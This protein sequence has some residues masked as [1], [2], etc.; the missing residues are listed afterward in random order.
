MAKMRRLGMSTEKDGAYSKLIVVC[1]AIL[2]GFTFGLPVFGGVLTAQWKDEY[3]LD[4]DTASIHQRYFQAFL[5]FGNVILCAFYQKLTPQQWL[6]VSSLVG[7]VGHGVL[8]A[9]YWL[10]LKYLILCQYVFGI[11]GGLGSGFSFGLICLTPQHW[12]DKTREQMN[13]YL[14]IGAPI[15]VCFIA[16]FGMALVN[17]MSW[18]G[19]LL[20]IIAIFLHQW[21]ITCFFIEHPSEVVDKN[22]QEQASP[23]YKETL[24]NYVEVIK[25]DGSFAWLFNCMVCSGFIMSGVFTEV[26]NVAVES[27][28]PK[29]WAANLILFSAGP[30]ALLFRPLWGQLTKCSDAATLQFAWMIVLFLSQAVLA[31]ATETWMFCVGMVLFSCGVSG[32]SGL[33]FVLHYNM[34]GGKHMQ[35]IITFD[36]LLAAIFTI[37]VPSISNFFAKKTGNPKILFWVTSGAA[38]LCLFTSVYIRQKRTSNMAKRKAAEEAQTNKDDE[39]LQLKE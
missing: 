32:Y 11:L 14:F 26:V 1:S 7:T 15:L 37:L 38:L 28:V 19:A 34:V 21:I 30:E 3:G 29:E 18:S 31:V 13:P 4:V 5:Y 24:A 2:S 23:T 20:M 36:T 6:I 25:M 10:P 27:G 12:L 22:G 33:K 8:Y 39:E 9:A 17:L 16:P 35:Y